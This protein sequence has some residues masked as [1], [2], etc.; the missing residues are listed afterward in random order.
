MRH[1]FLFLTTGA[2]LFAQ[3][4]TGTPTGAVHD[5]SDSV[6]IGAKISIVQ[7]E[8]S[9]RRETLTNDRGE[10][11][12]SYLRRGACSVTVAAPGFKGQTLTGIQLAVDQTV[13]LPL[14]CS[15]ALWNS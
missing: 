2:L 3:V 10:F 9:E 1:L 4:S 6:I 8:T 12:A 13:K 14:P 15:R 5:S 7:I 11:N